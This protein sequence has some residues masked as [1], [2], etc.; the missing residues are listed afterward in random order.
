M[1]PRDWPYVV[2]IANSLACVNDYT[3]SGA[4]DRESRTPTVFQ[5]RQEYSIPV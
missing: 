5:A 2:D 3:Y 1:I 4:D